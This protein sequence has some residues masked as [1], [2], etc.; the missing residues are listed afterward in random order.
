V[1]LLIPPEID[2]EHTAIAKLVVPEFMPLH[3]DNANETSSTVSY[4]ALEV[5]IIINAAGALSRL[6]GSVLSPGVSTAMKEASENFIDLPLFHTRVGEELARITHNEAACISSGAAAGILVSVAACLAG[7]DTE[8]AMKLPYVKDLPKKNVLVWRKH[9][10][11]FLA[12]ADQVLE[13]GYLSAITMA[14]GTLRI[15]DEV[16][17]LHA[18]D[19]AMLWFPHV[20]PQIKDEEHFFDLFLNQAGLLGIPFIVDAADQIPPVSNLWY[21]TRDKGADLAIFS[22]GKG[23]KGPGS[24]GLIVGKKELVKACRVNSGPE[25]S[26]GRPA[27]VGKE[28]I[29]GLLKAVEEALATDVLSEAAHWDYVVE[30]WLTELAELTSLGVEL[31]KT[32]TSHSGQPIPRV[33]LAL[34][35]ADNVL[36]DQLIDSLWRQNPGIAVLPAEGVCI[37]LNPHLIKDGEIS[38][39]S[40]SIVS[41]IRAITQK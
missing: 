29:A 11:G 20:Y 33:L 6:G 41:A 9:V 2:L 8:R 28:E 34:T 38:L 10:D 32:S 13:N 25:H 30:R 19:A 3:I 23:L 35:F 5:Q 12:G 1:F 4:A 22:G 16:D 15:I 40:K 18:S 7:S 17:E 14:G 26:I 39:V 37:A 36:R 27:K 21:F 24:S 31:R